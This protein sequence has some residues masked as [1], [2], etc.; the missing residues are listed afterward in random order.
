[1]SPASIGVSIATRNRW[2]DVGKTLS[3]VA[4][5][6]ELEGCPVVV[7]DDGSD[8]P[9]PRE[10]AERFPGVEFLS[11][12]RSQ[13]ASAQRTRIARHLQTE[14]VLQLDDDSYPVGGSV[15][16]AVAFLSGRP[17]IV[18]LALNVVMGDKVLPPINPAEAP[19][20]VEVFIGCGVLFR[21]KAFLE[22][23]GFFSALRYYLE[24]DHFC[25]SA[26]REGHA[27]YMY[28]SLVVR[29]EKSPN[30]RVTGRIAY[31]KGRNRVLLVLWHYPISAIPLRMATSLPG[32]L[33]LVRP[34]DY[35]AAVAGF[36]VGLFDGLRMIGQRR[37][38]S[39]RQFQSWRDLPS[40]YFPRNAAH[41]H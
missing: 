31:F 41:S 15:A 5:R 27:I 32:T 39:P 6:R 9:V 34:R 36:I 29:H 12:E 22:L 17:G 4:A 10:L 35:P 13:G 33:V 14:Y 25:A 11:S 24:E 38:L 21:R 23:G 37:P 30:A 3:M 19:Y 16:D 28:P 18:A 26:I 2:R 40:C 8:A 20:A 1:M 7:V